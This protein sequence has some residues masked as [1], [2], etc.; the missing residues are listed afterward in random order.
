M[1]I[2]CYR[3]SITFPVS[4]LLIAELLTEVGFKTEKYHYYIIYENSLEISIVL[5]FF[6]FTGYYP[7]NYLQIT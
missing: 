1:A 3:I 2:K 7:F 6:N 5:F 4:L